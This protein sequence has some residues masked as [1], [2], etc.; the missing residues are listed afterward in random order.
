[1]DFISP[2][3]KKYPQRPYIIIAD[4]YYSSLELA[5]KLHK[6][7][8]GVLLSC[9]GDR[10][11]WLFSNYLHTN[12]EKKNWNYVCNSKFSAITYYDKAKVNLITNLFKGDKLIS[13][14]DDTKRLPLSIYWYCNPEARPL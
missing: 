2:L 3:L 10:P 9:R 7:K 12:L 6:L 8:L 13:N 1:M 4:S 14:S 11:N 5:E